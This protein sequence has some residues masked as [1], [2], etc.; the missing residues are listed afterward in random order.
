MASSVVMEARR[1][2]G[3]GRCR[4]LD[5]RS[6]NEDQMLTTKKGSDPRCERQVIASYSLIHLIT[7]SHPILTLSVSSL[8]PLSPHTALPL[9]LPPLPAP[10]CQSISI[11]SANSPFTPP[12]TL[13]AP[14]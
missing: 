3:A 12:I 13:N 6:S 10:R 14:A 4:A 9:L 11:P 8:L 1:P 5:A 2:N 7:S